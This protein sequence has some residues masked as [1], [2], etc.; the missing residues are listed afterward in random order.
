MCLIEVWPHG[1]KQDLCTH[2]DA[3]CKEILV[4]TES[5]NKDFIHCNSMQKTSNLGV[6]CYCSVPH[7]RAELCHWPSVKH[8]AREQNTLGFCALFLVMVLHDMHLIMALLIPNCYP[9]ICIQESHLHDFKCICHSQWSEQNKELWNVS[10]SI[11]QFQFSWSCWFSFN[12]VQ[13]KLHS[14]FSVSGWSHTVFALIGHPYSLSRL[15]AFSTFLFLCH[16]DL[17]L[18]LGNAHTST[19]WLNYG[20]N[21]DIFLT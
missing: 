10:N 18:T 6:Q 13:L 3:P 11:F 8:K 5:R 14:R 15:Y 21:P 9:V 17:Q 19:L 20:V 1:C 7:F 16:I 2:W 4:S 12:S